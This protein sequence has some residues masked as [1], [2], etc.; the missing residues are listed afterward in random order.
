MAMSRFTWKAQIF[1]FF[2]NPE[3]CTITVT[4]STYFW[5]YFLRSCDALF[6]Q[7]LFQYDVP[8]L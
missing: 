4:N 1:F 2:H 7:D 5:S 3:G 8:Q 6:L